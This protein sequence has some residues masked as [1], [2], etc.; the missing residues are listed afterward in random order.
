L[1]ALAGTLA[2]AETLNVSDAWVRQGPPTAQVLGA[3]MTLANPGA[4][5]I[6]ITSASS[7]QFE[8]V[9]IHRTEIVDGMARMIPQERLA[10]PAGGRVALE[11]GG[12]HLMLINA[13]Q[14]LAADATVRIELRLE[15]GGSVTVA[16]P[17]RADAGMHD[18]MDHSHH[19]H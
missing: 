8:T 9:E 16:A 19:H 12:L 3:Y 13:K 4:Q 6:A 18:G 11:P 5:E 10:I 2:Q 1:L 14:P 15:G 7:P 17:V